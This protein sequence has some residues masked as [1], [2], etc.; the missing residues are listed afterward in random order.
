MVTLNCGCETFGV[1]VL[2]VGGTEKMEKG[3]RYEGSSGS[4]S[5]NS[6]TK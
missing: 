4:H 6:N 1:A 5:C 2:V 3:A